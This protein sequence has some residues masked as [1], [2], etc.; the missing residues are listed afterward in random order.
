MRLATFARAGADPHLGALVEDDRI[1]DLTAAG[2]RALVSLQS[3]VEAGPA[4]LETARALAA[5]GVDGHVHALADVLL[6]APF[7]RPRK[8]VYCVGLNFRSHVQQNAEA[9]GMPFEIP[10]VPLFFSK[11]VTAVIG[12][13]AQI[14]LD[15]RLT[16]KLDY[17][18]E[19]AVVIGRGGTWIDRE[20]AREHIFGYTLVNDISARDLQ[21]RTSQ[22]LYGKGLDTYC[23]MGPIVVTR[24]ELPDVDEVLIELY[25]NGEQRQSER[26]G[27]ML[28]PAE[29]AIAEL[30]KGITLDAG[31]VISLGTPGG[32]GYQLVPPVFLRDGDRVEC[33]AAGIGTLTN[34]VAEVQRAAT[35][36]E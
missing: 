5:E 3:L 13:D 32:C 26:A 19:L 24:D 31:D 22:F 11:P 1:V 16:G 21:W 17:E 33:R 8:N 2:D 15:P 35:E 36:Q 12:P 7:P 10:D 23:P 18:V 27:N 6:L 20:A 30:S 29:V 9:L 4:A 34:H 28:F 25:V 14:A